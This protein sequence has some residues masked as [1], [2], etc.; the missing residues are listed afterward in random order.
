MGPIP[1]L[2]LASATLP[3][4]LA[5]SAAGRPGGLA[6]AF[7][8]QRW[9]SGQMAHRKNSSMP[10]KPQIAS[11]TEKARSLATGQ[12]GA[13]IGN[14][15]PPAFWTP[16]RASLLAGCLIVVAAIVVYQNSL[17]GEFVFDDA[18][19]VIENTSI[20]HLWPIWQ[21]FCPPKT[22][23]PV[24]GRPFLNFTF[25]LNYAVGGNQPL[26]YHV[27]NL[28]IHL[29][30]GLLLFGIVG[31]TL[32]L[33]DE[34][35]RWAAATL[36]A[37]AVAL[38]WAV[39]PLQTESVTYV[40]Q[41]AESLVG[42]F[43]LLTLYCFLR[44]A[45]SLRS[46]AWYAATVVACLFGMASKE[47]MVT[48]PVLV[49]LFDRTFVAGSFREAWRRRWG[50][51]GAMA[52]TWLLLGWLVLSAENRGGSAGLGSGMSCWAYLG[53][54]FG[55]I[56]RYL[57]LSVWP[58][59]LIFDYGMGTARTA[60]E[61]VPYAVVVVIL[62]LGT[63]LTLWRWPK[64]GFL[65]AW[66]FVIL[67]PTSSIVPV[68]TQTIA[69]HRTY[70]PLAGVLAGMVF[71]GYALGRRWVADGR[72]SPRAAF[73]AGV[74]I[75]TVAA[76]A[77][78]G[79]TIARN[80]DYETELA[81]WKD[82]AQKAPNNA[83]A[84]SNYGVRLGQGDESIAIYRKAIQ[85]DP[86]YML[87]HYNLAN[88]LSS[89]SEFDEAIREYEVALELAPDYFIARHNLASTLARAGRREEAIEQ[90]RKVLQLRPDDPEAQ[91]QLAINL[92]ACGR[93]QDAVAAYRRALELKPENAGAHHNLAIVLASLSQFRE[94]ALQYRE[95][96][97]LRPN[98]VEACNNLALLLASCPEA[99]VRDGKA[100]MA[101]AQ[102]AMQLSGGK[103][104]VIL[105]TLAA[106]YAEAGRFPEA[107]QTAKEAM[108]LAERQ[109]IPS[110]IASI[111]T[112]LRLYEAG[113]P[114]RAPAESGTRSP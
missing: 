49:L 100:A 56:V 34:C 113:K 76:V 108:E 19:A 95:A 1:N 65:A 22:G 47:V 26:G 112:K 12:S 93:K 46:I 98:F 13:K 14:D 89:R 35:D 68:A 96:L 109:K 17:G 2:S 45:T 110:L 73:A 66:F 33:P 39:H 101:L 87:A 31:R 4:D 24:T 40:S 30:N 25:A 41:R 107:V 53:T 43:Y 54:Q 61:I 28:V 67:A 97:R 36:L 44:G 59:P 57:R 88:A 42:F 102:Q 114:Y 77:C 82:A 75:L 51:Y 105:D 79:L 70:L 32:R 29:C 10:A 81:I 92:A 62:V 69:E 99:S 83:R 18:A 38:L 71:G 78:G 21:A 11:P 58:H 94:A 63:L 7:L 23:A 60:S 103:E 5:G 106:A 80:V 104:P 27:L 15:A 37:F 85:L 90:F 91:Y 8:A 86:S 9:Y 55:A 72:L 48:A 52:G 64:V 74:G 20:Q 16:T 84:Q 3:E 6:L 111:Q 50:V